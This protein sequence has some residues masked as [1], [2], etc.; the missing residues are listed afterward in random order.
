MY[1]MF[2]LKNNQY[3]HKGDVLVEID[4]IDYQLK[5]DQAKADVMKS[6]SQLEIANEKVNIAKSNVIKA[7]SSLATSTSMSNR[8]SK[9]YEEDAGSLQKLTEIS[10]PKSTS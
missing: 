3:V 7:E 2:M 8:Y 6:N 10:K 9:L 5:E 4:P 1:L